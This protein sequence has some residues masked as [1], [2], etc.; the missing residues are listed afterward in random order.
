VASKSPYDF[1]WF[2]RT[3]FPERKGEPCRILVRSRRLNSCLVEFPDG[4][5]V[6]T[7]RNAVRKRAPG[8]LLPGEVNLL[9]EADEEVL[10]RGIV[11]QVQHQKHR[12]ERHREG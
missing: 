3:R 7:S 12:T 4:F 8:A 6:V 1:I 2:W 9:P 10:H 5:R 11:D